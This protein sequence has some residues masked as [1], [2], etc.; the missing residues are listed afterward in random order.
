[1][2]QSQ[3]YQKEAAV[4]EARSESM[5]REKQRVEET[6]RAQIEQRQKDLNDLASESQAK[7]NE[8]NEEIEEAAR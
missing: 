5:A 3:K 7:I 1:L 6:L 8:L 4:L 2:T